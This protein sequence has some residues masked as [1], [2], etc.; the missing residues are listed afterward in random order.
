MNKKGTSASYKSDQ[1]RSQ[2]DFLKNHSSFSKAA[3]AAGGILSGSPRKFVLPR[4]CREENLFESIRVD[5]GEYFTRNKITWHGARAHLLS[6]QICCLNFLA[7]F[8]KQ[9]RALKRFLEAIIGPIDRMIETESGQFVSFEYTGDKDYLNEWKNGNHTRG[10][11]CTS[12]DAIVRSQTAAGTQEAALIEW[13]Y[14]ERYGRPRSGD[15]KNDERFRRYKDLTFSPVGP[16]RPDLSV[17][18]R[19][20]FA[21]PIFQLYRQ[22]MLAA[23]ML[24]DPSLKL[25]RV[26]TILVAPQS[27]TDLFRMRIP[28]LERFGTSLLSV[29]RQ[30]LQDPASFIFC[31]TEDLFRNAREAVQETSSLQGWYQYIGERYGLT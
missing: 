24:R 16:I 19:D 3:K 1:L 17:K 13:K 6:S 21:E 31:S 10:A 9:P 4:E 15:P 18:V 12:V 8:S 14:T 23:Q 30:L 20:L 29:W 7:P 26:R 22:Q 5:V 28:A 2:L 27:N 25:H 11:N